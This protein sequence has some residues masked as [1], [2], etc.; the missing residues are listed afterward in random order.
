MFFCK[1]YLGILNLMHL[2]CHQNGGRPE[3]ILHVNKKFWKS[4]IW[5]LP[6]PLLPSNSLILPHHFLLSKTIFLFFPE[7]TDLLI[8][9]K[10]V[11]L[12]FLIHLSPTI[13]SF[14]LGAGV[15]R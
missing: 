14:L 13:S 15:G 5:T 6:F 2:L 3:C 4:F 9:E 12:P 1:E 11:P 10:K 8:G 7:E